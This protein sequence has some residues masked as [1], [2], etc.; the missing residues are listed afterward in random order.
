VSGF[1][2]LI[3]RGTLRKIAHVGGCK[4]CLWA[5]DRLLTDFGTHA[6]EVISH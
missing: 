2:R 3:F 1:D 5:N 6:L 4:G